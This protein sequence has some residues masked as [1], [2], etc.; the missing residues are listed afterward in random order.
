MAM[1]SGPTPRPFPR[2]AI[3]Q[4][5]LHGMVG[6]PRLDLRSSSATCPAP[7]PHNDE[8]LRCPPNVLS[9]RVVD[10][11]TPLLDRSGTRK[12]R[13][14]TDGT[15]RS[16]ALPAC[17]RR[18]RREVQKRGARTAVVVVATWPLVGGRSG[19]GKAGGGGSPPKRVGRTP[20]AVAPLHTHQVSSPRMHEGARP[21]LR[22][23]AE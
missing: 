19:D 22:R 20:N 12:R 16:A 11:A 1:L 17:G 7:T 14:P 9:G 13:C 8:F 4:R 23:I 2:R 21:V 15:G 18:R 5:L 6:P 10:E 3:L